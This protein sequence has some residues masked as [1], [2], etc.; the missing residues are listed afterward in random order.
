MRV[1]CCGTGGSMRTCHAAGLG[2]IPSRDKFPGWHF[3]R[4]SSTPV[5]QMS[6]SFRPPRSPNMIWPSLSSVIIHYGRQWPEMLTYPKTFNIHQP[7]GLKHTHF[8]LFW[9]NTSLGS[10]SS[11]SWVVNKADP[12]RLWMKC[13]I[14]WRPKNNDSNIL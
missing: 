6:G 12:S 11:F 8:F 9:M 2:S 10:L 7:C 4:G 5:R 1:H 13:E 14:L 3:F